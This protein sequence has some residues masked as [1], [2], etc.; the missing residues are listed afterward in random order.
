MSKVEPNLTAHLNDRG[1]EALTLWINHMAP[2][3]A[4]KHI[5]T[6]LKMLYSD[7]EA[8]KIT[9]VLMF[10]IDVADCKTPEQLRQRARVALNKMNECK[11][12]GLPD[13]I[14]VARYK[15]WAAVADSSRSQSR[16][17]GV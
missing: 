7:F 16:S 6:A 2:G 14:A 1:R 8:A 5:R 10:L 13:E 12:S 17:E 11:A 3:A 15:A 9:V 4:P